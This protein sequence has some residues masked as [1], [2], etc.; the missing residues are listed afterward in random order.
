[1][2]LYGLVN[3]AGTGV[4]H[5]VK[6]DAMFKT[7]V[8][9]TKRM[10]DAFIPLLDSEYGRIV[11]MSSAAGPLFIEKLCQDED[12]K[13]FLKN[14]ENTWEQLEAFL[15]EHVPKTPEDEKGFMPYCFSKAVLNNYNSISAR[16]NPK[17]TISAVHPGFIDTS[18]TT[19][20]GAT[21]KPEDG[22][23]SARHC[24]LQPLNGSGWYYGADAKRS[25][26]HIERND[27]YPEYTGE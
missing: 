27:G 16:E 20:W 11:N 5:G 25:P 4:A 26:L 18:M 12:V 15:A 2:K 8:F 19:G 21:L 3:N 7:N 6:V 9:G 24:L 17:L 10:T 23:V 14:E 1:M 13:N 22:T